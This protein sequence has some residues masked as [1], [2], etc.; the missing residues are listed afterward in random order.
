MLPDSAFRVQ[1]R[2]RLPVP[3]WCGILVP[4]GDPGGGESMSK[5]V[6]THPIRWRTWMNR[7]LIALTVAAL[8]AGL[9]MSQWRVVLRYAELL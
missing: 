6:G 2:S 4:H 5:G 1:V 9:L 3:P 7:A 8:V